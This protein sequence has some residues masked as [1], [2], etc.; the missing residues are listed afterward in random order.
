MDAQV[1]ALADENHSLSRTAGKLQQSALQL[2]LLPLGIK[3][4]KRLSQHKMPQK[5]GLS[6]LI[7]VWNR[8][9]PRI[10]DADSASA[11]AKTRPRGSTPGS[12][13]NDIGQRQRYSQP[14]APHERGTSPT[15][16]GT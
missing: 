9:S 10:S 6:S 15:P 12:K 1:H 5:R 2:V 11:R 7:S 14:S 13:C 4:K 16:V 8:F 3:D